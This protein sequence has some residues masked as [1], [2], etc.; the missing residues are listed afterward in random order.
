MAPAG[1]DFSL[2][3]RYNIDLFSGKRVD[4]KSYEIG[5]RYYFWNRLFFEADVFAS[6]HRKKGE[7]KRP[8]NSDPCAGVS[9]WQWSYACAYKRTTPWSNKALSYDLAAG[10]GA[11]AQYFLQPFAFM[12]V[13]DS[14]EGAAFR[15]CARINISFVCSG[16]I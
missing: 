9:S 7:V 16:K 12:P 15:R 10:V 1:E 13:A 5:A 11:E 4:L 14:D 3:L 6:S 8:L 2:H